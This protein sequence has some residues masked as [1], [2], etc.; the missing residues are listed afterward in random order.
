[1][2][3]ISSTRYFCILFVLLISVLAHASGSQDV[4]LVVN[5]DFKRIYHAQRPN[6]KN[7][8]V[9]PTQKKLPGFAARAIM[10]YSWII[11]PN[12][13]NAGRIAVLP[14]GGIRV[15][16]GKSETISIIQR[17]IELV[18]KEKYTC[19]LDI[20]GKGEVSISVDAEMPAPRSG[21]GTATGHAKP[22]QWS[23]VHFTAT[24]DHHRHLATLKI[25]ISSAA[26]VIIRDVKLETNSNALT[27]ERL[28][29]GEVTK[30]ESALFHADFEKISPEIT[31]GKGT[32]LTAIGDGHS[33]RGL[34]VSSSEA[35]SAIGLQTGK[36]PA[37][38]TLEF[39]YKP[40]LLPKNKNHYIYPLCL[41]IKSSNK[42]VIQAQFIIHPFFGTIAFDSVDKYPR[43]MEAKSSEFASK[44]SRAKTNPPHGWGWWIPGEW[45]H[46]AASWD[47]EALRLY[48]DGVLSAINYGENE[49]P[50]SVPQGVAEKLILKADGVIDD[51]KIHKGLPYGPIIPTGSHPIPY[52]SPKN[53]APTS[54]RIKPKIQANDSEAIMSYRKKTYFLH[55]S[56]ERS[57]Y[58]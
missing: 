41:K 38:G 35:G 2:N 27:P 24:S 36:L 37:E 10:P 11:V 43:Y 16:T 53:H 32:Q 30:R 14:D 31:C 57:L 58:L 8:Y 20:K 1:M 29:A 21:C 12:Q 23:V 42:K 39:W 49:K 40:S 50:A 22:N 45:H 46:L 51:I 19:S 3:C 13:D 55:S 15:E 5:P 7:L 18:P 17:Y 28:L 9:H 33:G 54:T 56:N 48:V 26:N 47:N 34:Q 44:K 4:N 52:V 6:K 25:K